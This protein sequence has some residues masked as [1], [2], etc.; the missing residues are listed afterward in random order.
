VAV[1]G[2]FRSTRAVRSGKDLPLTR[3]DGAS[4]FTLPALAMY[5]LVEL[6]AA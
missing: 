2:E 5:E 6:G 1:A 4:E 3:R